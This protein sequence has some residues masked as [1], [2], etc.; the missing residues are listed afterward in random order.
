MVQRPAPS[1]NGFDRLTMTP[2]LHDELLTVLPIKNA[3][4]KIGKAFGVNIY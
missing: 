4:P 1:A 3:L 2:F